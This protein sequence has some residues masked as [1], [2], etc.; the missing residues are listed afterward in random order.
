MDC[1]VASGR[2]AG[3]APDEIRMR[4]LSDHKFP[5]RNVRTL[6]LDVALEAEIIV[7]LDQELAVDRAMGIVAGDTSV[8]ECFMF[9]NKWPALFA[10]TLRATLV[11]ARH[12]EA[13][14]GLHDVVPVRI[15]ALDAI[16]HAFDHGVMLR[17]AE[18]G[19]D[20]EVALEAGARVFTG[21]H[22]ELAPTATDTDVLTGGAMAGFAAVDRSELDIV[23]RET[24]VRAQREGA[25]D[26][27]VA[28]GAGGVADVMR[29]RDLGRRI[30]GLLESGARG[31]Y[32]GKN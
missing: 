16:H 30:G 17:Q 31:K 9:E 24:S 21:I 32:A 23:F 18:L 13:A 4:H 2:P 10:M 3:A 5:G 27:R 25:G 29:T 22:D 8:A 19:V 26:I 11:Q 12:G 14:R 28:I 1:G 15:V 20:I 7:A 6:D